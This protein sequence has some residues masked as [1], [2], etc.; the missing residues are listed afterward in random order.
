MYTGGM[1]NGFEVRP[2]VVSRF[3]GR[4]SHRALYPEVR[5]FT[6]QESLMLKAVLPGVEKDS[7]ELVISEDVVALNILYLAGG[8]T[9]ESKTEG[10]KKRQVEFSRS[11]ELPVPVE[12]EKSEATLRDGIL[13]IVM[14]IR[15]SARLRQIPV[16]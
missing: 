7:V 8:G 12:S 11:I 6:G 2:G 14:P 9:E 16:K 15:E 5:L 10:S 1:I 3:R 13:T 4:A